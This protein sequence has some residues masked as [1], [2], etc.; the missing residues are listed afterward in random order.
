MDMHFHGVVIQTHAAELARRIEHP[1]PPFAVLDVRTAAD[2]ARERLPTSRPFSGDDTTAL[3]EGTSAATEFF[4][5][6]RDPDD[7]RVRDASEALRRHGA[8]RVVEFPGGLRE[9]KQLG[10]PLERDG[11]G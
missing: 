8:R 4:V 10:L 1:W 11:S 6:G 9:W 2:H 7:D 3:P 5:V